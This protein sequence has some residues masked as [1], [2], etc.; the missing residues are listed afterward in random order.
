MWEILKAERQSGYDL[1]ST[2]ERLRV[3]AV[4]ATF[5]KMAASHILCFDKI[6]EHSWIER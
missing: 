5:F 6:Q 4:G 2:G 3:W 1:C